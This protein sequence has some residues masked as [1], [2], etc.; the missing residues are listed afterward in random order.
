MTDSINE[1]SESSQLPVTVTVCIS[2]NIYCCKP[3]IPLC[4]S[5]LALQDHKSM[6][7]LNGHPLLL[8]YGINKTGFLKRKWSVTLCMDRTKYKLGLKYMETE[9]LFT[10]SEKNNE[11]IFDFHQ[12]SSLGGQ[13]SYS[14]EFSTDRSTFE[15][16]LLIWRKAMLSCFLYCPLNFTLE[17]NVQFRKQ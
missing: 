5:F 12:N 10:K 2:V 14:S 1:S 15:T 9:A 16:L 4:Y 8:R 3:Y 13:R 11:R 7:L 6:Q 17:I